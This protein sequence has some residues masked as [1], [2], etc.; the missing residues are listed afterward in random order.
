MTSKKSLVF[1]KNAD[2]DQGRITTTK[3]LSESAVKEL[4]ELTKTYYKSGR[5]ED[6]LT[7]I[8]AVITLSSESQNVFNYITE[9]GCLLKLERIEEAEQI[10][11]KLSMMLKSNS[12]LETLEG[13]EG[14]LENEVRILAEA[15][16]ECKCFETS[17]TLVLI[18]H[19]IMKRFHKED[20]SMKLHIG[21]QIASLIERTVRECSE[22]H[23]VRQCE[24][25]QVIMED[26]LRDMLQVQDVD[27]KEKTIR[28]AWVYKYFAFCCDEV[29]NF[30]RSV[31]LN[32]QGITVMKTVFGAE[33][34]RYKI[35]GHLYHNMAASLVSLRM[36]CKACRAYER[37]IEIYNDAEDWDNY[38]KKCDIIKF[39]TKCFEKIC[40][41]QCT[42]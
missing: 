18:L 33:A 21:E 12:L 27:V 26:I 39:A 28:V 35:F 24:K 2:T 40:Q 31:E 37:A 25:P 16:I 19:E 22:C 42:C 30:N 29:E 3:G 38:R 1:P 5:F 9:A 32:R 17:L 10:V 6:V 8:E 41:K 34:S 11:G 20:N 4:N 7:V 13:F 36:T 15:F 23:E 14:A